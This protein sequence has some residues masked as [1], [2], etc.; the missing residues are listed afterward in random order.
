MAGEVE[1]SSPKIFALTSPSVTLAFDSMLR[2]DEDYFQWGKDRIPAVWVFG[3]LWDSSMVLPAEIAQLVRER[4]R[5]RTGWADP[6]E[7][8]YPRTYGEGAQMLSK[9]EFRRPCVE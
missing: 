9:A 1:V 3:R 5:K 4:W 8:T 7:T 2:R 6:L